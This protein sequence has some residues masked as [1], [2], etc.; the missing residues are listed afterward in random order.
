V[1]DGRPCCVEVSIRR[2]EWLIVA[3]LSS[4]SLGCPQWRTF[5][6]E[7]IDD[8]TFDA[9][10]VDEDGFVDETEWKTGFARTGVFAAWDRDG[11]GF[12]E[13]V[14][15]NQ[16]TADWQERGGRWEHWDSNADGRLDRNEF[17]IGLFRAWDEDGNHLLDMAEFEAGRKDL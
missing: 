8:D 16:R 6:R 9:W 12:I 5:S 17:G 3:T 2:W 7:G 4:I 10:N 15:W 11:R 13:E 1:Y 14:E